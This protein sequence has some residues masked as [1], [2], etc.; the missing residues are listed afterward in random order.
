MQAVAIICHS[1]EEPVVAVHMVGPQWMA[2]LHTYLNGT[3][4][5]PEQPL[6]HSHPYP[7][8]FDLDSSCPYNFPCLHPIQPILSFLT[9]LLHV[10]P[11]AFLLSHAF[12]PS[13]FLLV[14]ILI[15]I[16][17]FCLL[18]PLTP[19]HDMYASYDIYRVSITSHLS[20]LVL[21]FILFCLP[22]SSLCSLFIS[23]LHTSE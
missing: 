23:P 7:T 13:H 18:L 15:V 17:L 1:L 3:V 4:L 8:Y 10:L 11:Y 19:L 22:S 9:G 16:F 12:L 20:M 2:P 6:M 21:Y 14:F 5:Y